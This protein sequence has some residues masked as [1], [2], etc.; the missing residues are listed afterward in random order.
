MAELRRQSATERLQETTVETSKIV[1]KAQERFRAIEDSIK[2]L[3][4]RKTALEGEI[5]GIGN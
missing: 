4:G 5:K 2:A 3:R 1:S